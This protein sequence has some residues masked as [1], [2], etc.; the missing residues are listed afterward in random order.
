MEKLTAYKANVL[1]E[2]V[3][4][5]NLM[6]VDHVLDQVRRCIRDESFNYL[7]RESRLRSGVVEE[8]KDIG[9]KV[10]PVTTDNSTGWLDISWKNAG[11]PEGV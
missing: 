6:S 8:L 3:I 7:V 9:Y 1:T 2:E 10:V 5:G 4:E 11:K